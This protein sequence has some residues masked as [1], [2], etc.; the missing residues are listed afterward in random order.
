MKT[1]FG[2]VKHRHLI[3]LS[4][5]TLFAILFI[6]CIF[7]L[8]NIEQVVFA[9]TSEGYG[10]I[11]NGVNI[12]GDDIDSAAV[13]YIQWTNCSVKYNGEP[14]SPKA[15]L[16]KDGDESF[17]RDLSISDADKFIG[18]KEYTVTAYS[19][20][21][22]ITDGN[23]ASF[24]IYACEIGECEIIISSESISYDGSA[25]TP[26]VTVKFGNRTLQ[27]GEDY[28][29][30]YSNNINAGDEAYISITGKG[31]FSGTVQKNFTIMKS[32]F[33]STVSING[34][35]F[36]QSVNCPNVSN[37][38]GNGDINYLY[39]NSVDGLFSELI[40]TDAGKYYVKAV[41]TE[42]QNYY[43]F[44]TSPIQFIISSKS[45]SVQWNKAES[46]VFNG[47]EQCPTAN[48]IDVNGEVI[49]LDVSGAGTNV[50]DYT[51][52]VLS[53]AAGGN[54]I[55]TN[56]TCQYKIE[57][58][59]TEVIWDIEKYIANG[60]V[61]GPR[62]Y[63]ITIDGE[64]IELP[65]I[66][67]GTEIGNYVVSVDLASLGDNYTLSGPISFGYSIIEDIKPQSS[68]L[69][70]LGIVFLVLFAVLSLAIVIFFA[71]LSISQKIRLS[72]GFISRAEKEKLLAERAD[73]IEKLNT[74]QSQLVSYK[75]EL[76]DRNYELHLID[77]KIEKLLTATARTTKK[78]D[79]TIKK[80]RVTVQSVTPPYQ[81]DN[82]S[83]LQ[84]ELQ[85][86]QIGVEAVAF[87]GIGHSS[88][89][90]EYEQRISALIAQIEEF[91][92][93][94]GIPQNEGEYETWWHKVGSASYALLG[95]IG[96]TLKLIE[97]ENNDAMAKIYGVKSLKKIND[98]M[99]QVDS[100]N[101]RRKK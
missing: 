96:K 66:G 76:E 4:L 26:S 3:C 32:D 54:Y 40:P 100:E 43:L 5:V 14:Q 64:R 41:I 51:V 52:E 37:N 6:A 79:D 38:P 78:L 84:Y 74:T 99:Q 87:M 2:R 53:D 23:T 28:T 7:S 30:D 15:V 9:D 27:E 48:Y 29:I 18:A 22:V 10:V 46:Y 97:S 42:T 39:S 71:P 69:G 67:C 88:S 82:I 93:Q 21:Y 60:S 20:S 65:V 34:W 1:L 92:K 36:G 57:K 35:T 47:K 16:R 85:R 98:F 59:S 33:S 86:L 31:N 12:S 94:K 63:V 80:A 19:S 95:E 50:G 73:L 44:E 55:L 81:K 62:A 45:T 68:L 91:E 25:K 49:S 13:Y 83:L 72:L 58:Y 75:R 89:S 11:T 77:L 17:I 70:S 8:S 101:P 90:V 24:V 61:Q 56:L